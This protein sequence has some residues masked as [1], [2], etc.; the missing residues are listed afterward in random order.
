MQGARENY[1]LDKLLMMSQWCLVKRHCFP[2]DLLASA[3]C[4]PFNKTHKIAAELLCDIL[5]FFP[6]FSLPSSSSSSSSPLCSQLVSLPASLPIPSHLL[7]LSG[8]D[9][10]PKNM[11]ERVRA[12]GGWGG[13]G[14]FDAGPPGICP[15]NQQYISQM[16]QLSSNS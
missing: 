7:P 5:T 15:L 11:L 1:A 16:W 8:S 12:A 4:S 2:S 3:L 13:G 9:L 10:A 14:A 6:L